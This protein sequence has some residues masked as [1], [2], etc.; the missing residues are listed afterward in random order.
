MMYDVYEV[1]DMK[2]DRRHIGTVNA[3][4]DMYIK[5]KRRKCQFMRS[6]YDTEHNEY[7]IWSEGE[8]RKYVLV[9]RKEN[10]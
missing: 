3:I 2:K 10:E 5:F 7:W 6:W 9:P 8:G 1:K 4:N